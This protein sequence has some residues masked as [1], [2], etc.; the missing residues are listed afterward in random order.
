MGREDERGI[1][2]FE[3]GAGGCPSGELRVL[4]EPDIPGSQWHESLS[5]QAFIPLQRGKVAHKIKPPALLEVPDAF[6]AFLAFQSSSDR[7]AATK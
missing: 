1:P 6:L 7:T 2:P 4:S 5:Y 3:G